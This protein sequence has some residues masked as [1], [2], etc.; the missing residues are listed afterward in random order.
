[1]E[2][3]SASDAPNLVGYSVQEVE[4]PTEFSYFLADAFRGRLAMIEGEAYVTQIE[5]VDRGKVG[6]LHKIAPTYEGYWLMFPCT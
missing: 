6:G 3:G 2:E 1:M 5:A 4:L